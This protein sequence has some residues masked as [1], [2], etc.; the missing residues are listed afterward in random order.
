MDH[1][2]VAL[3]RLAL[4]LKV[5]AEEI[6]NR[7]ESAVK[8]LLAGNMDEDGI[9]EW[10]FRDFR[11]GGPI[12]GGMRNALVGSVS[13]GIGMLQQAGVR[14]QYPDAKEWTWVDVRDERECEDCEDRHGETK[15]WEEWEAIGLPG[16]GATRC[17]YR[18]RC[19]LVP[20]EVAKADP[21]L[22][23]PVV[24]KTVAEYRADYAA[25]QAAGN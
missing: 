15:T 20:A 2:E 6:G 19:E 10:L 1:S 12:F 16:V 8:K 7:L 11:E 9:R 23:N 3:Q 25:R 4:R 14:D 5:D 13:G 24:V 21:D 22:G 17:G 18:C